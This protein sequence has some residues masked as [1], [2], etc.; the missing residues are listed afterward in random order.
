MRRPNGDNADTYVNTFSKV[1]GVDTGEITSFYGKGANY[2][3]AVEVLVAIDW[4]SVY[5]RNWVFTK[6]HSFYS[7]KQKEI[8]EGK[9]MKPR[10]MQYVEADSTVEMD[11][12][13]K[14]WPTKT[15]SWHRR[16]RSATG[17]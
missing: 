3:K 10:S 16:T 9:E 7:R 14:H 8:G 1:E 13:I 5:D 6:H 12:A 2:E 11:A 17:D 15:P 4:E